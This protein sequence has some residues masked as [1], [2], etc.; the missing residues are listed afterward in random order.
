M[1]RTLLLLPLLTLASAV[2]AESARAYPLW[3][4]V[5]SVADYAKRVNLP[6]T[7]SIDLGN[8]VTLD[9]V[10]IPAG[11]FIM[12]SPEPEKPAATEQTAVILLVA[13]NVGFFVAVFLLVVGF[14]RRRRLSFSLRW[15]LLFTI[16]SGAIVGGFVRLHIAR[17]QATRYVQAMAIYE[18]LPENEKPGHSVTI[19]LPFYLGKYTVTYAQFYAVGGYDY[20]PQV[21]EGFTDYKKRLVLNG[22]NVK[23]FLAAE[24][25]IERVSWTDALEFCDR[26]N[27]LLRGQ[28]LEATL[29]TEAQ[30]EFAC[31]A[32]THT[33]FYSGD[34]ERDLDAI[35]WY[36]KNSGGH[37]HP[38]GTKKPNAFGLYDMLGN[39]R[40]LCRDA[41]SDRKSTRLNSS[42]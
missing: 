13:G 21:K 42:H 41:Y 7:K 9:L 38:V 18:K 2:A 37:T 23:Q 35:A 22:V 24:L 16:S 12:G 29:P 3:N 32:G 6:P 39:I 27:Y 5:E 36:G 10:L 20:W 4:G 31:R 25:P 11:K 33:Q 15:L 8:N 1:L 28:A 17:E 26:L 40:Q 30:W 34:A 14:A 19:T